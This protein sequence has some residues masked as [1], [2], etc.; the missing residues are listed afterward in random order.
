MEKIENIKSPFMCYCA[1][2]I[3][4]AFDESMSYYE[5]LCNFYN[6][7][8]NEVMPAINNNADALS[9]LQTLFVELKNYVDNYFENLDIQTEINNKLDEMVEQGT[10]ENIISQYI[11]LR[12]TYTYNSV[13]ELK[14]ATNLIDDSF[15]RTNGYYESNDGGG[16]FYKIREKTLEDVPNDMNIIELDDETLVA[17]LTIVNNTVSIKQLGAKGDNDQIENLYLQKAITL[18]NNIYIPTGNYLI[19]N[20]IGLDNNI[21]IY[22][23]GFS[24]IIKLPDNTTLDPKAVLKGTSL[25][26]IS[27]KNIMFNFGEQTQTQCYYIDLQSCNNINIE[28]VKFINGYG[29]YTRLNGSNN[30]HVN[31]CYFYNISGEGGS[32]GECIYGGNISDVYISN[33]YSENVRDH[34]I[35]I[36]GDD[37]PSNNIKITNCNCKNNIEN[38]DENASAICIYSGT[39]NVNISDINIDNTKN[40]IYVG[41]HGAS[42]NMPENITISNCNITN[43][44][45][46]CISLFGYEGYPVKN[47]TVTNCN[48]INSGQDGFLIRY[49][50]NFKISNCMQKGGRYGLE[51]RDGKYF[52][53]SNCEFGDSTIGFSIGAREGHDSYYGNI[54]NITIIDSRE[55]PAQTTGMQLGQYLHHCIISNVKSYGSTAYNYYYGCYDDCQIIG[56]QAD[57]TS[58]TQDNRSILYNSTA[59]T[60]LYHNKGDICFNTNATSGQPVGWICV[61]AGAPGTWKSIGTIA[62]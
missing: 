24:S 52:N 18:A 15:A 47:V 51:I 6:Y 12:T 20:R 1:K 61:T 27:I 34:F 53:I 2:V 55:E 59:P 28:N 17:E 10:L 23:D 48:L 3:P 31:N 26:N 4:L 13:D 9:E 35:Y 30:I 54:S 8:K 50:E 21:N 38:A 40:G 22:G 37:T 41:H 19:N 7:L 45:D 25:S 5:C 60:T 58:L 32:P 43:P 39:T 46:N 36:H 11:L 44:S 14:E 56:S 42:N 29:N 57:Y 33:C 49:V 16:A 62:N